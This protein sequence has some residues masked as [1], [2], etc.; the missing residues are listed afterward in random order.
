[1]QEI[2]AG[3]SASIFPNPSQGLCVVDIAGNNQ[4]LSIPYQVVDASGRILLEDQWNVGTGS[5]RATLDLTGAE[6]GMYRLVMVANG[7]P[8]SLQIVKMH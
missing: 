7:R 3:L 1:M 8:T 6:A 4:S 2:A 5:F